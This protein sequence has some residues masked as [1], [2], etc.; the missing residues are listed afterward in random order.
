MLGQAYHYRDRRTL[1][2]RLSAT[3][4][5]DKDDYRAGIVQRL[6]V[7]NAD[8]TSLPDFFRPASVDLIVTDAPY[9]VQH[10]S[11]TKGKELSRSPLAL[12][13]DNAPGWA[14]VLRPGG[15]VGIAWNTNVAS[16]DD[17]AAALEAAGLQV[18]SMPVGRSFAHRV[19]QAIRRDV[20]LARRLSA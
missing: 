9:G 11:R 7:I 6:E 16:G 3:F 15:A 20:I 14:R 17:A 10:G 13:A 12:I 5:A 4:A 8:T 19:D 1:G 18:V 2:R